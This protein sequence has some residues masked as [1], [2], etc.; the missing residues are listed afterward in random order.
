[1]ASSRADGLLETKICFY[2]KPVTENKLKCIYQRGP[3]RVQ[4]TDFER[5]HKLGTGHH[6]EVEIE[7]ELELLVENL[8]GEQKTR[9]QRGE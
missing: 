5:W 2:V 3:V 8:R 7:E 1:M 4:I 6:Q 9:I